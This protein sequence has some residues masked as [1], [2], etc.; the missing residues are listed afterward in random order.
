MQ[1]RQLSSF[2]QSISRIHFYPFSGH[3]NMTLFS[4]S[5]ASILIHQSSAFFLCFLVRT[6][7]IIF[8]FSAFI[9]SFLPKLLHV[10]VYSS[11]FSPDTPN[12]RF[13]FSQNFLLGFLFGCTTAL[14]PRIHP[15]LY[16]E[17]KKDHPAPIIKNRDETRQLNLISDI[18]RPFPKWKTNYY[19]ILL[20][21]HGEGFRMVV[22]KIFVNTAVSCL[23]KKLITEFLGRKLIIV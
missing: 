21:M 11:S 6:F 14:S 7:T 8:F 10:W 9:L 3:T 19:S 22:L 20:S 12:F 23:C 2:C 5:N 4:F 17:A 16:I 18:L 1:F 15:I 13:E